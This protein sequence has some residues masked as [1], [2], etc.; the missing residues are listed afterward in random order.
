MTQDNS[1]TTGSHGLPKSTGAKISDFIDT[2]VKRAQTV[3]GFAASAIALVTLLITGLRWVFAPA[4]SPTASTPSPVTGVGGPAPAGQPAPTGPFW[5]EHGHNLSTYQVVGLV[6]LGTVVV[7]GSQLI[8]AI[9]TRYRMSR[10]R[11]L[12]RLNTR[13]DVC[14]IATTAISKAPK[15]DGSRVVVRRD[16]VPE[17]DV[18][19][20]APAVR[21]LAKYYKDKHVSVYTSAHVQTGLD[22][23][24]VILG[25]PAANDLAKRFFRDNQFCPEGP[26]E[27][28]VPNGTISCGQVDIVRDFAVDADDAGIPRQDFFFIGTAPSRRYPHRR[29]WIAGGLTTYGTGAAATILFDELLRTPK[30][31]AAEA[32]LT[33]H[34]NCGIVF[35]ECMFNFSG[36]LADWDIHSTY[37]VPDGNRS[38]SS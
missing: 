27:L 35:G 38:R 10:A 13:G 18:I 15:E 37:H 12:F 29:I 1:V 14:I 34:A 9:V 6:V 28:D 26:F 31:H 3:T 16:L 8:G 2:H 19:A 11:S 25:S 4:E 7:L 33:L 36:Q 23:D 21:M 22:K 17:G 20:I 24:L 5:A 32:K 30:S